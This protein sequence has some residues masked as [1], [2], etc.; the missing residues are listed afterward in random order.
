MFANKCKS[1]E[2]MKNVIAILALEKQIPKKP[3]RCQRSRMGNDYED[4][5]CACGNFI[6]Y[7]PQITTMLNDGKIPVKFCDKCGQKLDWSDENETD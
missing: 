4:Y 2:F 7:E 5:Y 6:G 3:I 1:K